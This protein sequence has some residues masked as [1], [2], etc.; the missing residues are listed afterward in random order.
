M[1]PRAR[2]PAAADLASSLQTLKAYGILERATTLVIGD[3]TIQMAPVLK[4]DK[5][6]FKTDDPRRLTEDDETL[7]ASS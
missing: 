3:V 2:V 1:N 6:K 4:A 5:P 7:F